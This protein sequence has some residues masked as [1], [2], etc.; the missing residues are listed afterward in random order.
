MHYK[1]ILENEDNRKRI[2]EEILENKNLINNLNESIETMKKRV[3]S[4]YKLS[5]PQYF[6]GKIQLLLPPLCL[7]SDNKPDL[8]LVVTKAANTYQGHTCITL[9]MAYNNACLIVKPENNWLNP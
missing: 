4:N 6:D 7:H 5:I 8:A 1:H 2:P 3:S 9:D